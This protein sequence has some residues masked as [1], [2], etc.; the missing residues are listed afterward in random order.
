MIILYLLI[1]KY[2]LYNRNT[3]PKIVPPG[4]EHPAPPPYVCHCKNYLDFPIKHQKLLSFMFQTYLRCIFKNIC[5]N[6]KKTG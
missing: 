3:A 4:A 2:Y 6:K 1:I 5:L